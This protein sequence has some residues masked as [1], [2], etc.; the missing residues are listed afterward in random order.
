[1][2]V[3]MHIYLCIYVVKGL[4]R[5]FPGSSAGKKSV[6]MAGDPCLISGPGRSPGER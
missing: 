5:H 2:C 6:Y 1:M 4:F 3:Y